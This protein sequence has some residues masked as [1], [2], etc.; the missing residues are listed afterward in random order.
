MKIFIN[1]NEDKSSYTQTML[2]DLLE[3]IQ[4]ETLNDDQF[5]F[6]VRVNDQNVEFGSNEFKETSLAEVQKLEIE[7]STMNN[8]VNENIQNAIGYLERLIP[9]LQQ[10]AQMFREGKQQQA[11]QLFMDVVD[12]IDWFSQL[13]ELV[14][15]ARQLDVNNT[16]YSG[17]TLSDRKEKLLKMTQA[18]LEVHKKQDWIRLADLLEY[19]FLP[20]YQDWLEVLPQLKN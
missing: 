20:Y 3:H 14:V 7:T 8:M 6:K 19:E 13:V 4:K 11:N 10:V 2:G 9:G 17:K 5:L 12:G 15:Q 16:Q 18:V 1:G